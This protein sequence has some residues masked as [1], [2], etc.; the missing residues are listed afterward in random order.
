MAVTLAEEI[1]LLS[2]DDESGAA[3]E[4]QSAAWAVAGG[5]LLDLVLA[6]RVAVEEG[7]LRVTDPTPTETPLL[8]GRL[9]Q[10]AEWAGRRGRDPKVT[11]WLTR[12]HTKAVKATAESLCARGL[13]REEQR[14]VLGVFPVTRYP[15][16]DGAAE[17]ELRDR[18]RAVV[19]DGAEPDVR[20]AGLV[21][22][23]HGAKLHR[24]AFPG[25]PRKEIAA[26]L[27]EIASGQWAAEGVRR[28]IRDMQAAMVAVTT[29]TVLTATS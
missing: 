27:D 22:L 4:R 1:M 14:K 18:L 10:I 24:L 19:L 17:R 21:G 28:A 16:A 7:R 25:V 23:V 6:G 2:L 15:E 3:K 26:R 20:T 8:D 29:V 13:V 9:R 5:I 11:E 12:D